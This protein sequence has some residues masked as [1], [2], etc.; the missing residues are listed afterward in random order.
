[1]RRARD[2]DRVPRLRQK[3]SDP[4]PSGTVPRQCLTPHEASPPA[5]QNSISARL[6]PLKWSLCH[7]ALSS[8]GAAPLA[9]IAR[10]PRL[11]RQWEGGDEVSSLYQFRLETPAGAGAALMSEWHTVR[12]GRLHSA[13]LVFD[14]AEFRTVVPAPPSAAQ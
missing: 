7:W 2:R 12:D 13:R 8:A 6:L 4:G 3:A 9:K 1:M 14:T 5:S 10:G 11:L